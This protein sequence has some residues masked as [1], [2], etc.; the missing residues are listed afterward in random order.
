MPCFER[1]CCLTVGFPSVLVWLVRFWKNTIPWWLRCLWCT[2][3]MAQH[4]TW[5]CLW[6]TNQETLVASMVTLCG[7]SL[8]RWQNDGHCR[9]PSPRHWQGH[10]QLWTQLWWFHGR[11]AGSTCCV[12]QPH[13][14]RFWRHCGGHGHWIPHNF[15]K[16]IDAVVA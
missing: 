9:I 14:Q 12:S 15:G 10:R 16:A 5:V 7:L 6:W 1:V 2:C 8:H 3:R 13:G 4:G 11:A